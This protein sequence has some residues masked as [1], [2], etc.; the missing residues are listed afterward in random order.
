MWEIIQDPKDDNK[1]IM[2]LQFEMDAKGNIPTFL[3]NK[4]ATEFI[5]SWKSFRNRIQMKL[6]T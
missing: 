1:C 2:T 5:S 6:E 4:I 3:L